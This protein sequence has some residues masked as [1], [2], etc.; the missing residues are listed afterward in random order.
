MIDA[1]QNS[2]A[3]FT[4]MKKYG[5]FKIQ[6]DSAGRRYVTKSGK[7][8]SFKEFEE[9]TRAK[10]E[11]GR[12]AYRDAWKVPGTKK[13]ASNRD[14]RLVINY[15]EKMQPDLHNANYKNVFQNL[16]KEAYK[17]AI[18]F[19]KNEPVKTIK[20]EVTNTDGKN[21]F[22]TSALMRETDKVKGKY[23]IDGEQVDRAVFRSKMN[24]IGAEYKKKFEDENPGEDFYTATLLVK[25][26]EEGNLFLN[27]DQEPQNI[28]ES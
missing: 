22:N 28:F 15:L 10:V 1:P 6:K 9:Y 20:V 18:E 17:E 8:S 14:K 5:P 24:E 19:S 26:D 12:K 3:F 7:R 13:V 2:G 21:R 16:S 27:S 23:H 25:T 4:L 11:A